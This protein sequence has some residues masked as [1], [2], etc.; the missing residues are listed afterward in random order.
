MVS[1]KQQEWSLFKSYKYFEK[2]RSFLS[3]FS[4]KLSLSLS[5]K[6]NYTYQQIRSK[7]EIEQETDYM[8]YIE[9]NFYSTWQYLS[10]DTITTGSLQV[11]SD[12][13]L[14][15][16]CITVHVSYLISYHVIQ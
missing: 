5:R 10:N 11:P 16:I 6:Q 12:Q 3:F 8:K 9:N 1:T 2:L 13:Y 15:A 7:E 4:S 14:L